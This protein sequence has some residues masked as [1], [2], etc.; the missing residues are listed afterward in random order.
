M[1]AWRSEMIDHLSS[2]DLHGLVE[3][4]IVTEFLPRTLKG[5]R[6]GSS[7]DPGRRTEWRSV[8]SAAVSECS[9]PLPCE[10]GS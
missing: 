8:P 10:P 2:T 5:L 6:D 3:K 1:E 7:T 9:F 4:G